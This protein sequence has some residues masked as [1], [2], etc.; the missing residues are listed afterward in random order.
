MHIIIKGRGHLK[1]IGEID[2]AVKGEDPATRTIMV[3][4]VK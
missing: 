4:I 2:T 3:L 1:T